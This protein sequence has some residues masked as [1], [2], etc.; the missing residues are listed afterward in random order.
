MNEFVTLTCPSCG[1]KLQITN[2]VERF[3]CAHC[4]NEH[5]VRRAGGVISLEPVV[6]AL[7]NVEIGVDKTATELAINRL[8]REINELRSRRKVYIASSPMLSVN[9]IFPFLI[10]CGVI[11]VLEQI[12][13]SSNYCLA[14]GIILIV[15]GL[16]PYFTLSSKRKRWQENIRNR[17]S[18]ID[19]DIAQR[20]NDLDTHRKHVS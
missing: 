15:I 3:S 17:L 7:K 2:D 13:I 16:I 12:F 14:G 11:G 10:L 4:G 6:E 8:Q 18:P 1:G 20:Q 5:I 9:Y 19:E